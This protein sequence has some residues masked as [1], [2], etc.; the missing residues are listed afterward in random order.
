MEDARCKMVFFFFY[1]RGVRVA[2]FGG[3]KPWPDR[4]IG[5]N[6]NRSGTKSLLNYIGHEEL[7]V[8][9]N[10]FRFAPAHETN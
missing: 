2:N 10:S 8:S 7:P 1:F 4:L 6:W 3:G 9:F 5:H